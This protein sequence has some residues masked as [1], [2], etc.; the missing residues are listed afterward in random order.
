MT[1]KTQKPESNG[2]DFFFLFKEGTAHS[3]RVGME[4]ETLVLF[5]PCSNQLSNQPP[6]GDDIYQRIILTLS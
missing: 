5:A 2:D 1:F 4:P 6:P 3:G